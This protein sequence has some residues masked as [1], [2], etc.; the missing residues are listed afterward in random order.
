MSDSELRAID[1]EIE[2][3]RRTNVRSSLWLVPREEVE[4]R[5]AE[6]TSTARDL[7]REHGVTVGSVHYFMER[8]GIPRRSKRDAAKG[9]Q[10]GNRNSNWNG[11]KKYHKSGYVFVLTDTMVYRRE[12]V[13][14]AEKALG[15]PLPGRA[16][17]HHV[18]YSKADNENGNLVICP[19]NKYHALLHLRTDCLRAGY[20]PDKYKRCSMGHYLPRSEFGKDKKRCDGFKLRCNSCLAL[21]ARKL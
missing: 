6:S 19:D 8:M 4:R 10:A 21:K 20:D 9:S 15:R 17:V 13:V 11:G 14:K 16:L 7:A 2:P 12:H 5:Y 18:N 1:A 3:S